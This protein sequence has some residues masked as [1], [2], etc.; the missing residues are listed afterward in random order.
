MINNI[1][2]YYKRRNADFFQKLTKK[3]KFICGNAEKHKF[4]QNECFASRHFLLYVKLPVSIDECRRLGCRHLLTIRLGKA[5]SGEFQRLK[6]SAY[7]L[8][9]PRVHN[10]IPI[11]LTRTKIQTWLNYQKNVN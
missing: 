11:S 8:H 10:A 5:G 3:R 1:D 7:I 4:Q 9:K 2:R 6:S